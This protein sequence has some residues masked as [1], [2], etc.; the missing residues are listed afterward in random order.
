MKRTNRKRKKGPTIRQ[1]ANGDFVLVR[2]VSPALVDQVQAMV[3]DPP[4]PT[5]IADDGS[6]L[7]NPNDPT[8]QLE[9]VQA[10][11]LRDRRSLHAII[12][13]G[14][15]LCNEEG[16]IIDP[17]HDGWEFKLKKLGVNWKVEIEKITG[18]IEDEDEMK[19]ARREAYL[20]FVGVSA[21]DMDLIGEIAGGSEDAQEE[22]ED[23]FPGTT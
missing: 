2:G 3:K 11:S 16:E 22:A 14:M 17:P 6:E 9:I 8:Y 4:I 5:F 15:T 10:K 1:L 18:P 21:Y 7:L 13:F 23:M 19:Q 12:S 20:L